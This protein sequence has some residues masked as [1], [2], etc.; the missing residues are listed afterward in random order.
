MAARTRVC[1]HNVHGF[2]TLHFRARPTSRET[3]PTS[4]V[5]M[6]AN[7]YHAFGP[8]LP[9]EAVEVRDTDS[10]HAGT[11]TGLG[12]YVSIFSSIDSCGCALPR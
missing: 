6:V 2:P 1:G 8:I 4:L 10:V 9:V 7:S 12:V 3:V 11:E 5:A